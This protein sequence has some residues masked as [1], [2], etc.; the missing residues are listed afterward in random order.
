MNQ[1][2]LEKIADSF[3]KDRSGMIDL[4][5]IITVLKGTNRRTRRPVV[6]EESLTDAQKIENEVRE[7]SIMIAVL[8]LGFVCIC[9]AVF[10]LWHTYVSYL[11]IAV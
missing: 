8:Y 9:V 5:E 11:I 3:D 1:I 6:Q 4:S 10:D 2:E 7:V